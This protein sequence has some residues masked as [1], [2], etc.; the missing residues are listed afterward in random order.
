MK[1]E[2]V[3]T[4]IHGALG[5]CYEQLCAIKKLRQIE[6]SRRWIG[7]FAVSERLDAMR[8]FKLDMLDE[9][10]MASKILSVDVDY[11]Y[12]FQVKDY[13]LRRDVIDL[14]PE[15]IK[16]KFDLECNK[17]PWNLI[18]SHDFKQAGLELELS[19]MGGAIYRFVSK[20]MG[21]TRQ[22]L[23]KALP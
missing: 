22:C 16:S 2:R 12:Q 14:L 3:G 15:D 13:E 18:K 17:K 1:N 4:I 9:V 10:Y 23:V 11:F 5:D 20:R 19:D 21:S 6:P 7:F 8:H